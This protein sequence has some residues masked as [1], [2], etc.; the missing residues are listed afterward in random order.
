VAELLEEAQAG[1]METAAQRAQERAILRQAF[2]TQRGPQIGKLAAALAKAQGAFLPIP[3][4][5]EVKVTMKS[6]GS[7]TFKYAPLDAIL[8][9][10]RPALSANG[11]AITSL[12]VDGCKAIKTM[13]VHES[14][15]LL[16]HE[17]PLGNVENIQALGSEITYLRRYG[18]TAMLCIAP[19]EDDDGN[20]ASGNQR[21]ITEREPQKRTRSKPADPPPTGQNEYVV[22]AK[23]AIANAASVMRLKEVEAKIQAYSKDGHINPAEFDE[24]DKLVLAKSD[25]L[26]KV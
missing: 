9:A 8:E 11:L 22:G 25:D 18:I 23:K 1:Q 16:E 19:D 24:L 17:M 5:R 12:M 7:Y 15:E 10:V 3:K 6:G 21:D 13:L 2:P 20:A 4:T 26:H 14:G